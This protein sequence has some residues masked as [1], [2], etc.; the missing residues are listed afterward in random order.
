M[1]DFACSVRRFVPC[2]GGLESRQNTGGLP[3]VRLL[4]LGVIRRRF[5][6]VGLRLGVRLRLGTGTR[7]DNAGFHITDWWGRCVHEWRSPGL[8][9]AAGRSGIWDNGRAFSVILFAGECGTARASTGEVEKSAAW[10]RRRSFRSALKPNKPKRSEPN[11]FSYKGEIPWQ[12]FHFPDW[13]RVLIGK[14]WLPS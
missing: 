1:D 3:A 12:E 8:R 6:G 7:G 9:R 4:V 13:L 14:I 11:A 10:M 2:S 5:C